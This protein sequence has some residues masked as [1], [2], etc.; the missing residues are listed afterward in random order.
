MSRKPE[1]KQKSTSKLLTRLLRL[2]PKKVYLFLGIL[3]V[4]VLS[5]NTI[6]YYYLTKRL[7]DTVI[8]GEFELFLPTLYLI[9]GVII[10]ELT[11]SFLKTKLLGIFAEK[12]VARMRKILA[13]KLSVLPFDY[14]AKNH[15]G[16]YVSRATNDMGKIRNFAFRTIPELIYIPLTAISAFIFLCFLSW[17]L[18]IISI[19]M[20]P[21]ILIGANIISKPMAPISKQLQEKLAVVNTIA[22]DAIQG[23]E[24]SKAFN[25]EKILSKRYNK[26]VDN[27]VQSAK[28]L[29]KRRSVLNSFSDILSMIPVFTTFLLGGYFIIQ[30]DMT[31]G[32]IIAFINC[33][34][35]LTNPLSRLPQ[36]WGEAKSDLAAA[37]RV[38][39]ILDTSSERRDGNKFAINEV[40]DIITFDKVRF[41]YPGNSDK[42]FKNLCFSIKKGETVALV[43]PSGGGKSTIIRLLL[44]YYDNY[45]GQIKVGGHELKEWNLDSLRNY[46]ALVN[47]DTFLFPESIEENIGYGKL[48]A[49]HNEIIQASKTAN[50]HQF[51]KDFPSAYETE[52]G[53]LGNKLSGGQKQRISIARAILKDAPILLLDEPTS[54][55]DTESEALIQESL[56]ELMEDRTS[57]VIAHRLSTIKNV[58]RILVVASGQIVE[59]GTH[60]QLLENRGIYSQLYYKQLKIDEQAIDGEGV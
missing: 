56:D 53:E 52:V 9:I 10:L 54:A 55:L 50:S 2:F 42:I 14:L 1:Y 41:S 43:G 26:A 39:E 27:S 28:K 46:I 21:I 19:I 33:L 24:I 18:T 45:Q 13:H 40:E 17:K 6:F 36:I 25:L 7:A 29:A 32:G 38:F 48:T 47:Q 5:L 15:S 16:D 35:H 11:L 8:S 49:S 30:G 57:L 3:F 23:I 34:S 4:I 12:G 60:D 31:V 37:E 51:I 44:G 20:I 58:D 22:Q 59:E